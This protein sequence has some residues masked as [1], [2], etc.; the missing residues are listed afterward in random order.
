M[1]VENK[2]ALSRKGTKL[3]GE[4]F[5]EEPAHT[6]QVHFAMEQSGN[7]NARM[8]RRGKHNKPRREHPERPLGSKRA[9]RFACF[10]GKSEAHPML[11]VSRGEQ[12]ACQ[13][14]FQRPTARLGRNVRIRTGL[15]PPCLYRSSKIP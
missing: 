4:I 1:D 11:C 13:V 7:K 6:G 10:V 14:V 9:G 2:T 15:A 3:P 5:G 12:K 8:G